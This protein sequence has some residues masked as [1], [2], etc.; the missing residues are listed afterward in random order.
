[1]TLG[2]GSYLAADMC[3]K[4]CVHQSGWIDSLMED[5]VWPCPV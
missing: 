1:M 5:E 2:F 3:T 4:I